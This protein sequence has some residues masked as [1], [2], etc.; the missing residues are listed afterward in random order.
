M[1]PETHAGISVRNVDVLVGENIKQVREELGLTQKELV[2]RLKPAMTID[3]SALTRIE[4]G[5]RALRVNQLMA[6]SEAL[7][8]EV[9]SLIFDEAVGISNRRLDANRTLHAARKEVANFLGQVQQIQA[10][11]SG[12][13]GDQLLSDSGRRGVD[14]ENYLEFVLD[15]VKTWV[16]DLR[17]DGW[18]DP[19]FAASLGGESEADLLR[20]IASAIIEDVVIETDPQLGPTSESGVRRLVE[21]EP[22]IRGLVT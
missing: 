8:V 12:P 21:I 3:T 9:S 20:Q 17:F 13:N 10:M 11:L 15:Q 14:A 18:S 2:E 22:R 19:Y 7:D 6:F 16:A 5:D 4:K 1:T